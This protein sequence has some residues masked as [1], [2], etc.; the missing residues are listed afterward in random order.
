MPERKLISDQK[1]FTKEEVKLILEQEFDLIYSKKFPNA[2]VMI[3]L[4]EKE[5]KH[6]VYVHRCRYKKH[7]KFEK[8]LHETMFDMGS[9]LNNNIR[10]I[11]G[12]GEF[13]DA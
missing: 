6:K 13:K 1:Y 4:T 5:G 2:L 8:H 9:I 12:K 3:E 10:L 7:T 11:E